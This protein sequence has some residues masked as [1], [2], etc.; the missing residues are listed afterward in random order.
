MGFHDQGQIIYVLVDKNKKRTYFGQMND[1]PLSENRR[2]TFRLSPQ[3]GAGVFCDV[4]GLAVADVELLE[5]ISED[6]P[7][8]LWRPR[9][10]DRIQTEI[11]KAFGVQIEFNHGLAG[12]EVV[13]NALN[14]GDVAR[15]QIA[16]LLMRIPIPGDF[17]AARRAPP[18][19][20][21]DQGIV[22][23]NPYHDGLGLFTTREDAVDPHGTPLKPRREAQ[24]AQSG[25]AP[26]QVGAGSNAAPGA[27]SRPTT[28]G[29]IS[30]ECRVYLSHSSEP[31]AEAFAD[32]SEDG[33]GVP[34]SDDRGPTSE[35][36]GSR[37]RCD[38]SGGLSHRTAANAAE[39][40]RLLGISK[41]NDRG[42]RDSSDGRRSYL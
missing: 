42:T 13:A 12:L 3:R 20:S 15:A 31:L 1:E 23:N 26:N 6:G 39:R 4:S 29:D 37:R 14:E 27:S 2:Q 17:K 9:P 35:Q 16:A 32:R 33:T 25:P 40:A 7:R 36:G 21:K 8:K 24:V 10:A 11:E 34:N 19:R 28:S 30:D 22:K 38:G 5:L 18:D 41:P